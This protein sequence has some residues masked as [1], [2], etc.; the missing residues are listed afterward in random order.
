MDAFSG[1]MFG[2]IHTCTDEFI[3]STASVGKED[4]AIFAVSS[5]FALVNEGWEA[6]ASV[7]TRG[8]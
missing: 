8:I 1:F 6:I 7:G 4:T 3:A 2:H 5:S